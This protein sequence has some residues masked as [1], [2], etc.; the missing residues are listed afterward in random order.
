M[1]S[2]E[3]GLVVYYDRDLT[4]SEE[5]YKGWE[6]WSQEIETIDI[7]YGV[8]EIYDKMFIN[9]PNFKKINIP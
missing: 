5:E 2:D 1:F 4:V 7:V 8:I 9:L 6:D 3:G